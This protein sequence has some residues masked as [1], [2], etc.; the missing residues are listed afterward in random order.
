[1]RHERAVCS[2]RPCTTNVTSFSLSF[3]TL[4]LLGIATLI[5]CMLLLF[6]WLWQIYLH[7]SVCSYDGEHFLH[8][9]LQGLIYHFSTMFSQTTGHEKLELLSIIVGETAWVH[10][11]SYIAAHYTYAEITVIECGVWYL[12]FHLMC[13]CV[14]ITW[15]VNNGDETVSEMMEYGLLSLLLI[16]QEDLILFSCHRTCKI[17]YWWY[18]TMITQALQSH[19]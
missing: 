13:R 12:V 14:R 10:A 16:V 9:L 17:N 2:V 6:L 7:S 4:L 8:Y 18:T 1:M 5:Q 3:I 15:A 19:C 11:V